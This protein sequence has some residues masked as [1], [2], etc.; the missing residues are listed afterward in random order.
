MNNHYS[1]LGVEKSASQEEIKRA[2]RKLAAQHHPDRGGDTKK[3]QEIQAAYDVLGD[4]EKRQAYDNP[5]PS[6]TGFNFQ[7]S[8]FPPEFEEMFGNMF[9]GM[10]RQPTQKRNKTLN[11]Q[12]SITLEE[13][14]SGKNL[15]ANIVLPSGRD[16]LVEVRIPAGVKDGTTFRLTGL[17]DD[18]IPNIP[19]GD[20][21]LSIN[22]HQHAVFQRQNDDLLLSINLNCLDA[23]IGKTITIETIDKKTLE[24]TIQPGTQHGQILAIHGFGMPNMSNNVFRGRLL[25]SINLVVPTNLTE[26]QKK[27]I[28]EIIN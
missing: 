16:Q 13:A 1:T 9:G 25:L 27:L 22:V 10:F 19:R 8:G 20:I 15:I 28:R 21:H 5:S 6:H 17:G 11:I 23:I 2:Y 26:D 24:T 12:T 18:S 7:S 4:P 3:F 14:F